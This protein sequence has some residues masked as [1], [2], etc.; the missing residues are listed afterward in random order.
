[1]RALPVYVHGAAA[2][3]HV[4]FRCD[5][6]KDPAMTRKV[7][8]VVTRVS[9]GVTELLAFR[10]PTAGKQ[11]VKGGI[12]E[13]ETVPDAAIRELEEES[14][15]RIVSGL[16]ELGDAPI[17]STVWHFVA[18]EAEALPDRWEHQTKDDCGHVFSFFWHPLGEDLDEEWHPAFHEAVEVIRNFIQH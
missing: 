11:I 9:D 7:C 6:R 15:I 5:R 4:A 16:R 12:Q 13:N 3:G 18:V 10:H 8:P 1:M 2:D 17:G 14:G